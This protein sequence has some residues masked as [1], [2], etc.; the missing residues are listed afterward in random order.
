MANQL[1]MAEIQTILALHERG[2]SCRRIARELGVHRPALA[3]HH[4]P[5]DPARALQLTRQ[6]LAP[7]VAADDGPRGAVQLRDRPP[8]AVG[9]LELALGARGD[10][11]DRL[12]LRQ[13]VLR[14]PRVRP[15]AVAGE[16]AVGRKKFII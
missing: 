7:Q 9:E 11:G 1:K 5:A 16:V 4:Q 2:W 6:V 3:H 13:P 12:D 8:A 15:P 14:V 10:G